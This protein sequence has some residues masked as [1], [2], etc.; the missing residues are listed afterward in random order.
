MIKILQI[1]DVHLGFRYGGLPED[2]AQQRRR[3]LSKT[4][5]DALELAK[6]EQV[7]FVLIPGD[8]F[9]SPTPEAALVQD[10][11]DQLATI[12]PIK[13]V[14]AAGNHDYAYPGSFWST[15]DWPS[16]VTVLSTDW[17]TVTFEEER[18]QVS[19]ISFAAPYMQH[20][21]LNVVPD[22]ADMIQ[23]AVV[24]GDAL[25]P[26]QSPYNPLPIAQIERAGYDWLALGHIHKRVISTVGRTTYAYAGSPESHG[27][28]E[29]GA[30][31][32]LLI[33]LDKELAPKYEFRAIAQRIA[34][35]VTVDISSAQT[36]SDALALIQDALTAEVGDTYNHDLF[37]LTLTGRMMPGNLVQ[38]PKLAELLG[39]F[40]VRLTDQTRLQL[41]FETLAKEDTLEGAFVAQLLE[42]I[43]RASED[44][45]PGLEAALDLGVQAFEGEVADAN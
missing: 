18:V 29:L 17:E 11:R 36:N 33:T 20:S 23:I 37:E 14:I 8:L 34:E 6:T 22:N 39:V 40:D 3:D 26:D 32:V 31:G 25:T 35:R 28:D 10:V 21:T 19:G 12:A 9:D 7:S 44:E 45:R 16:N 5:R 27:Y 41:D 38:V 15:V 24:H 2:A 43:K 13:V 4:F 42:A 1:S 30:K